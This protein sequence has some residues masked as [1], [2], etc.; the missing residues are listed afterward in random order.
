MENGYFLCDFCFRG[1]SVQAPAYQSQR[2]CSPSLGCLLRGALERVCSIIRGCLCCR[3]IDIL[4][5][6]VT[7]DRVV[8]TKKSDILWSQDE[9]VCFVSSY[10]FDCR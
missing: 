5:M 3:L 6:N 8:K 10:R 2:S 4:L 9:E 1:T 7:L